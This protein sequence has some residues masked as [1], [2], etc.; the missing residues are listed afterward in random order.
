MMIHGV[1]KGQEM[2]IKIASDG[3]SY[4][5]KVCNAE[6]G[7]AISGVKAIT[8]SACAGVSEVTAT[9]TIVNPELDIESDVKSQNELCKKC[10]YGDQCKEGEK[11]GSN[12]CFAV[13]Q[14]RNN[15]LIQVLHYEPKN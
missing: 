5:T 9:I 7:E 15:P 3:T 6:T 14:R 10:P 2:R 13:L 8:I 4:G 12:H 1:T 11:P